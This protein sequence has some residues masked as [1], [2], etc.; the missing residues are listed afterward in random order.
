MTALVF[1]TCPENISRLPR[2]PSKK[3][4]ERLKGIAEI[5]LKA[6]VKPFVSSLDSSRGEA[7]S[8]PGEAKF[9]VVAIRCEDPARDLPRTDQILSINGTRL[10]RYWPWTLSQVGQDARLDPEPIELLMHLMLFRR[11]ACSFQ[12]T[13]QNSDPRTSAKPVVTA[14][15]VI[16]KDPVVKLAL[17]IDDQHPASE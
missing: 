13:D 2:R 16:K 7:R 5:I 17:T 3:T 15:A 4:A 12:R 8:A 1:D 10:P 11:A 9:A 6:D 14:V